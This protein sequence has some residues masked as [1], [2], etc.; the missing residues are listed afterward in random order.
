MNQPV[1][2]RDTPIGFI[3]KL[4]FWL[5]NYFGIEGQG[6]T[7]RREIIAG[8]TTFLAAAYVIVVNP[9]INS[10]AGIPFSAGVT[11]TVLV[12]FLGT[13]AMALYA[14]NPILI[15]P[16]MGINILFAYTMVV[17]AKIPL[18]IALGCVLWGSVIFTVLAFFNVR[19]AVIDG[20]PASLRNAISCGMGLFIALIGLVNAKF[21]SAD[22]F[23]V[24]HAAPFNPII[25]T[26]LAG[27]MVTIALVAR[28]VPGAL[29]LGI[30][31]TTLMAIPI[32]RLWGDATAYWPEGVAS[33]TLV[34]WSGLFAAPDFSFLGQVD[35][36]GSLR[37]EYLPYI[38]VLVFTNFFESLSTFLGISEA[39][40]LK[41]ADG[42]P[43]NIKQSMHV[44]ALAALASA[45]LGTSP[46]TAYIESAAGISQGGRT[47]LVALVAALLFLPFLF[48]SPLLSLVPSIATAPVLI[49]I[50]VFMMDTIT[51]IDWHSYEEAIP[52]FLV[53]LLIPL[54]YSITLGIALGFIVFVLL[55]LLIGKA[56]TVKP[57]M[58]WVAA[59]SVFLVMRVQY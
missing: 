10:A 8:A 7:L 43:R 58:W 2:L 1:S 9:D 23:T 38:F 18:Q 48:L 3:A 22:P 57:I 44:D 24:V 30:I 49:M 29:I 36:L 50:G 19:Q 40:N 33:V 13:L 56:N 45:P 42:N 14:K 47:G 11:A 35:L 54:T 17:G 31:A 34:N 46:A 4:R 27:L 52:A 26:F 5:E 41:D 55:K 15:A 28:K 20:I 51:K 21:I 12:S 37:L 32:G 59:L 6:S 16:G 39:G 25:L 53:I